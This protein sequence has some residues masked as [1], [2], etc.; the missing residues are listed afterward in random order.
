MID[1][2]VTVEGQPMGAGEERLAG[3]VR[4]AVARRIA[5]QGGDGGRA[6][7]GDEGEA[8]SPRAASRHVVFIR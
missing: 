3:A 2:G 6:R 7:P 1:V 8:A 4:R 5:A